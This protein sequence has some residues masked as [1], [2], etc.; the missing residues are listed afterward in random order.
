MRDLKTLAVFSRVFLTQRL[1][2]QCNT[3]L[4]KSSLFSEIQHSL[5]LR[6]SD[7]RGCRDGFNAASIP[8]CKSHDAIRNGRASL[9]LHNAFVPPV[10]LAIVLAIVLRIFIQSHEMQSDSSGAITLF[11]VLHFLRL[12]SIAWE[13]RRASIVTSFEPM[14]MLQIPFLNLSVLHHRVIIF[15]LQDLSRNFN[16]NDTTKHVSLCGRPRCISC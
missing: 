14:Q 13:T 9:V 5:D 1:T 16:D 8:N 2:R 6:S 3:R 10:V 11:V 12:C 15:L 4:C 7:R